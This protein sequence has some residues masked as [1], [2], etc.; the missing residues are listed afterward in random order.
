VAME[1]QRPK[2]LDAIASIPVVSDDPYEQLRFERLVLAFYDGDD[3]EMLRAARTL[4]VIETP[5]VAELLRQLGRDTTRFATGEDQADLQQR[6]EREG[7]ALAQCILKWGAD[8]ACVAELWP[9][10]PTFGRALLAISLEPWDSLTNQWRETYW[11]ELLREEPRLL[12]LNELLSTAA[13]RRRQPHPEPEARAAGIERRAGAFR[14]ELLAAQTQSRGPSDTEFRDALLALQAR[15]PLDRELNI[16]LLTAAV[17]TNDDELLTSQRRRIPFIKHQAGGIADYYTVPMVLAALGRGRQADAL[18]DQLATSESISAMNLIA[19][20]TNAARRLERW[21]RHSAT[22]ERWEAI[23]AR[24]TI[25]DDYRQG[26]QATMIEMEVDGHL[27]R[28]DLAQAE[29]A[30]KRLEALGGDGFPPARRSLFLGV[31]RAKIAAARGDVPATL[32]SIRLARAH[33]EAPNLTGQSDLVRHEAR[34]RRN[35]GDIEG[36]LNTLRQ[37]TDK[38]DAC[39][40]FVEPTALACRIHLAWAYVQEAELHLELGRRDAAR[41]ATSAFRELMP[42]ADEDLPFAVRIAKIEQAL[43][44]ATPGSEAPHE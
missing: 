7:D 30:A 17:Y 44:T 40:A 9:R 16:A 33:G 3:A 42:R 24:S 22:L 11:R 36:A 35:A 29:A 27:A 43:G 5:L 28:G 26:W 4:K 25:D 41:R 32:E 1:L 23:L 15:R 6:A 8:Q 21:S 13:S 14:A 19:N 12:F 10:T 20:S 37:I 31:A 38:A 34:A 18:T 2:V 39:L